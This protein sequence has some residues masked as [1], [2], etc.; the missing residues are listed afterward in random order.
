MKKV[1]VAVAMTLGICQLSFADE[2][3]IEGGGTAIITVFRPIQQ[4]FEKVHG[5]TLSIVQSSAVKGLIALNAGRVDIATGAHP[6]ED[7][8]A[9]AAKEGVVIDESS[10]VATQ[11]EENRL[12]V[13]A[14]RSSE[15][16][17]LSKDQL[18]GVFTGKILN[19]KEVGGRD[20]PI[21]VVWGMETQGQ[22]IQFTRIALDG[23]PVTT[24]VRSATNYRNI[25]DMVGEIPGSIGVVPLEITTPAT[26]S[27]D[28]LSITSPIYVITKGKPSKRVLAV[29]DFYKSEYSF[30][31]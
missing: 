1:I 28:T 3:K 18:K 12:I 5:H 24:K 10:L 15:V 25:A 20:L 29:V 2:I 21:N 7:L 30:L 14:N 26:R 8:I 19:W 6:L 4:R 16:T 31:K 27:L 23:E 11:I 17:R 9:G 22:N 13:T